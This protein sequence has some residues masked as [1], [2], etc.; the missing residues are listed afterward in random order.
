MS[1]VFLEDLLSVG[2]SCVADRFPCLR[3]VDALKGREAS[4]KFC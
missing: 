2:F 4:S 1:T 3:Y